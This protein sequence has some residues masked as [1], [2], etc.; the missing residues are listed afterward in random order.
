MFTLLDVH[1]ILICLDQF[2]SLSDLILILK[3]YKIILAPLLGASSIRPKRYPHTSK[4]Q[5][6][7]QGK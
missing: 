6:H 5:H 7:A 2:Y 1:L 3:F 4:Q